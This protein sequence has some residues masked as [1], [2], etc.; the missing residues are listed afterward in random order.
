MA[1]M[2]NLIDWIQNWGIRE[3]L[4]TISRGPGR[5]RYPD[6]LEK[7]CSDPFDYAIGLKN[8]TVIRFHEVI[9]YRNGWLGLRNVEVSGAGDM[10]D[11]FSFE[12]GIDVRVSDIS[13][14]CDAPQGS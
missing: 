7:A 11:T 2:H 12:R 10:A 6:A 1:C 9:S 14:V 13:W 8:G 4:R 3:A 5:L